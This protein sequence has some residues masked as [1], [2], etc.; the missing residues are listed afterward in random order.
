MPIR[1][2]DDVRFHAFG[3]LI[4]RGEIPMQHFLK[5]FNQQPHKAPPPTVTPPPVYT[6]GMADVV[7]GGFVTMEA[8]EKVRAVAAASSDPVLKDWAANILPHKYAIK[9]AANT[10]T[11][12]DADAFSNYCN[13][14]FAHAFWAPFPGT[15][16]VCWCPQAFVATKPDANNN[17]QNK[18]FIQGPTLPG[19]ASFSDR[20]GIVEATKI[21]E[22]ALAYLQK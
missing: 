1:I 17:P 13:V 2:R 15:D 12:S 6:N 7:Q 20:V 9:D 10:F 5:W 14:G 3:N 18:A 22:D 4:L 16:L 21:F 8:A 19:Y 11:L